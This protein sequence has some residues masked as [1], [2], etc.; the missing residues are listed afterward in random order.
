MEWPTLNFYTYGLEYICTIGVYT[1][2][3][4]ENCFN[5][6][7]QVEIHIPMLY[8]ADYI[9]SVDL[10]CFVKINREVKEAYA[11]IQYIEFSTDTN[12]KSEAIIKGRTLSY[13]WSWRTPT[14]RNADEYAAGSIKLTKTTISHNFR[15]IVESSYRV[16]GQTSLVDN[17]Q[18]W[19][20]ISYVDGT[21]D[22]EKYE[23]N[24]SISD[25]HSI[26]E[27]YCKTVNCGYFCRPVI[28]SDNTLRMEITIYSP[29]ENNNVVFDFERGNISKFNYVKTNDGEKNAYY[30][31][32]KNVNNIIQNSE[33]VTTYNYD[34]II[35]SINTKP[36][37]VYCGTFEVT[38]E[39]SASGQ[40]KLSE[41]NKTE[42]ADGEAE[43][44][45]YDYLTDFNIGDIVSVSNSAWGISLKKPV[46]S[47]KETWENSYSCSVTFGEPQDIVYKKL[48]KQLER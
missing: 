15:T 14:L 6:S 18:F 29:T 26:L 40:K 45:Y 27:N 47:V 42:S 1:S 10:D 33:I 24:S 13:L 11:I 28:A 34:N 4:W 38:E 43:V 39:A 8:F 16:P 32:K 31:L 17:L 41:F 36:K 5:T 23:F 22:S 12:G 37:V 48:R 19:G 35:G 2:L 20:G 9:S 46:Y 21:T 44:R 30:Y 7:G 25:T 3:Q